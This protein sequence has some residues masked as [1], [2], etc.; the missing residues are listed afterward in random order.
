MKI[1][2]KLVIFTKMWK[3]PSNC[4]NTSNWKV[5]NGVEKVFPKVTTLFP[6][7]ELYA[8]IMNPQMLHDS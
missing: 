4:Q 5:Q 6:Q 7:L 1:K 2:L 3:L 8:K